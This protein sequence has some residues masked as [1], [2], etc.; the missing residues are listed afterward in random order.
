MWL[1]FISILLVSILLIIYISMYIKEEKIRDIEIEDILLSREMLIQHGEE[2]GR[3][4]KIGKK[5]DVKNF[6][7]LNLDKNFKQIEKI[8]LDLNR[9]ANRDLPKASEW[10]LDNFYIIELQYKEIRE[11]LEKE[12]ELNLNT[13]ESGLLKGYPRVYI[14]A[15]EL[16]SHTEGVL[17]EETLVDFIKAYQKESILSIKE[18]SI[19]PLMLTLALMEYIKNICVEIKA[20]NQQW[21]KAD[22]IDLSQVEDIERY[23]EEIDD[24]DS[25]YLARL[26][27]RMKKSDIETSIFSLE[28]RLNYLGTSIESTI[29]KEHINQ[30]NMKV[31]MGNCIISL[32]NISDFKW[33]SIFDKLCIVEMILKKDPL[34][35][36]ENMDLESKNYYRYHVQKLA[37]N[38]NVKEIFIAKKALELAKYEYDKGDKGKK[39]HIGYYIID[40]GREE[41]F[42]S[43]SRTDGMKGLYLNTEKYYTFPIT[44]LTL[45]IAFLLARY[46]Y[47]RSNVVIGLLV[48]FVT[49]IPI[50]NIIIAIF[51]TIFSKRFIPTHLPKLELKDEIPDVFKTFVVIPT[52]LTDEKR[53]KELVEQLEI[54]YLSNREK[55][56][57]FGL[58]GDFKDGKFEKEENDEKIIKKALKCINRL[59]E[60][61]SEDEN[62]FYYFHRDRVYS[63]S[64]EKWM[65]WEKKRGA[66]VEFN[67]LILGSKDTTYS[68]VSSNISSL[69]NK[70]KYI[71]TLDADTKMPLESAR[72][73]IGTIG[74]PLNAAVVDRE[75]N[76]VIEGYGIIQPRIDVD[77]ESSNKSIFTRIYAGQG[78]IDPYTTAVSDIYQD[79]FGEGI[80]TG[81][82]I[83]DLEVFQICLKDAIPENTVLSHDLLES[84]YIRAGLATDIQL[85]DGYPEKY[86]S[87]I[88]RLHRWTRGDWQLIRWLKNHKKNPISS[89]SKWKIRDN[90]RRSLIPVSILFTIV[91]GLTIF[92]GN[93]YLWLGISL[94][95]IFTPFILT[96]VENILYRNK[97]INKIKLNGNLITG[98]KG[99]FYQGILSFIFLPYEA[100]M[101][102][103]AILRT[104]YRVIFSNKNLLQWT[105]AFDMEKKLKND[106]RSFFLRMRSS[107]LIGI[108][109]IVLTYLINIEKIYISIFIS[110]LWIIS[111]IIAY[112]ISKE[113]IE[114]KV[115]VD[116]TYLREIARKTWDYYETFTNKENNFLPPD[117]YQEY[118]YNGVAYRTSPTN[119]GFLWVS[120][121][122][123]RD[124]GYI[125]TSKMVN[126]LDKAIS[127]VEKMEKWEG[128]LY[129][130]YSTTNLEP[131]RPYFVST[132]DSGNFISYLYVLREG[133]KE[134]L[135]KPIMDKEYLQGLKDTIGLV[136]DEDISKEVLHRLEK[137]ENEEIDQLKELKN[138]LHGIDYKKD[139]WIYNSFKM[140]EALIKEYEHYILDKNSRYSLL[141]LKQYYE[142]TLDNRKDKKIEALYENVKNIIF[143]IEN[144][145]DRIENLIDKADFR[146]LYNYDKDLFS[147]GYIVDEKELLDSYYDLLAS[148]ARTTSYIAICRGEVP[149]KHW[150]KLGRSLISKNGYRSLA[151]WTGTMFEYLMPTLIMKNYRNTLLDETYNTAINIQKDYCTNKNIP[152]GISESGFFAFDV[153]LNYQYRAFGVPILGFKRGLEEDLVVSPYS[154]ILALNF[155]PR[156]VITNINNLFREK[157][158]G[159]YG[160]YEAIDFTTRRLPANMNSGIVK[161]YMTHH[162]GMILLSINNYLNGR[163]LIERFH[164]NV[165]MKTGEILLQEKIPMELI[166]AKEREN[167]IDL[168][169]EE[170]RND[171]ILARTYDKNSLQ[172]IECHIL[173][174][175]DYSMLITNMGLGYSKKNDI[176]INRWRKDRIANQYGSF[177]YINNL[178]ENKYWSTTYEPTKVEPDEYKVQFSNDKVSFYRKD[179]DIDTKM[180]IVLLS[181][182]DGEIRKVTLTNNGDEDVLIEVCSYFELVG[183]FLE[184][185]ISH[186]VFNNLFIR[187]KEVKE[188]EGLITNRRKRGEEQDSVYIVHSIKSEDKDEISFEY[189][190]NRLKFIGRGNKLSNPQG[191]FKGLSNTVGAVLDPIMSLK[192]RIKINSG[193]SKEVYFIT[194]IGNTEEEAFNILE[195]YNDEISFSKA[196]E[197]AYTRSQT[198]I[199]YLNYKEEDI[200]LYDRL[201]SDIIFLDYRVDDRYKDIIKESIKGQEGLWAYG[202]SGDIPILLVTIKSVENLENLKEILKAYGYWSFKGLAVDLII[203]CEDESSYY[204]PLYE[205]IQEAVFECSGNV[206]GASGSIYIRKANN[207]PYEDRALLFK[208]AS[209]VIDAEEGFI[210]KEES[211]DYIPNKIFNEVK[212]DYPAVQKDLDLEYFN[213]YGG[214]S[215]DGNEYIIKLENRLNTPLP[216]IN[217]IANRNFGFT[218][219]EIG[220]G[221]S[222]SHNSRENKLTPWYNDSLINSPGEIIYLRDD[223]TGNI[224]NITPSPIREEEEYI[225]THGQGYSNF[226][227]YSQGI[228][229]DLTMYVAL[230]HNI[231]MNLIKLK[232]KS[233]FERKITLVYFMRP[234]LG[235][236]DE[237]TDKFIETYM[238]EKEG[239]FL[240]KNSTNVD[241]KNSTMFIGCSEKVRSYTGNRREFIGSLG[242]LEEPEALEKERLSN[243]VGIG[244]D[245]CCAIEMEISIPS[246]SEKELVIVLAES[247]DIENGYS[248][249][250]KYSQLNG[251]KEELDNVKKYWE[252][253]LKKIQINTPEPSMNLMM[254]SWLMYQTIVSRLWARTGFYQV[255]GAFGGR[256]QIQDA[257][258]SLY[259]ASEECK[260]QILNNCSHQFVE[261]DIQHWWHPNPKKNVH[262]GIRSKY[263]DDLLWL[264]LAV[265]KYLMVTEDYSILEVEVPYIE[266]VVLSD[267]E[268]ERYEVPNISEKTGTVYEHCIKAIEKSLKFGE[269]GIPLMGS[270]DWNDGMNKV[271]YKGKGES[272]WLGWFLGT[273][274]KNFLPICKKIGDFNR[275]E[276]YEK[277]IENIKEAIEK[278]GWDGD[279]YLRAYFD[280]GR[281]LGS[282]ENEECRIDS[283]AQSWGVLSGLGNKERTKK[284]MEAVD[285][286]LINEEEGMILLLSPPF[287]KGDL[288]PGY[289]KSYVPGV[290]E[291]GGQYTHAAAWV[292][293][294][295]ALMGDG[296]KALNLFN[297][298]NPINHTRTLIECEKYKTEPYVMAADIYGIDPHMGRGGW[299]WYTGS[300]GWIYKVG[301]EYILGFRVEGEKLYI[302][303]CIP[304]EWSRYS[305]EYKYLQTTYSI[306]VRN[307]CKLNN[308]VKYIKLDGKLVNEE[309]IKLINDNK[310]HYVEVVLNN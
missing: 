53:V 251:A 186:P 110:T 127:S 23:I 191:L 291:N 2:L 9:V 98:V 181:E 279:W 157:M 163:I 148:E 308:G 176:F 299:T 306:E 47:I 269:R 15:I 255:G 59:N 214:F 38:L 51:N 195:K 3:T 273:V 138:Y 256:D 146:P 8:Y 17:N 165:E 50:S 114:E 103:D 289:I 222:W 229:Q 67:E 254:N 100:Y 196:F 125:T 71:I 257:M 21:K 266:S 187:T 57:Y 156:E 99:S 297:I 260:K 111:P 184:S 78:G 264:P 302:N 295:F 271:G 41:I 238:D 221:F 43:L 49:F 20:T 133:L 149:K 180:D 16:I 74:H 304:K 218:V 275:A 108:G 142:K 309:Y 237:V 101:M 209:L 224:W 170:E 199:G 75:R 212:K 24:I 126:L 77:I 60:K 131:L 119:I 128:H 14:L 55:N 136:E 286:Y 278:N 188:Y 152:W 215:K 258:N 249:V 168:E 39:S 183:D 177:I 267:E 76:I 105:T 283:I 300:S 250:N 132:V 80:F 5:I 13:L 144:L 95:A 310:N 263:S 193:E 166:V 94:L 122:S 10:L 129:N 46:A 91:L 35:V 61:Y 208:W 22:E 173:S 72:K 36:Y 45:S 247:D 282:K 162:Q 34:K 33:V 226:N 223:D 106:S 86:N 225:I 234:V 219:S 228:E 220:A 28:K 201:V 217:I 123:A 252:E 233:A 294:A 52:L 118:P 158:V 284:A 303:P 206:V 90:M 44:L 141:D 27:L 48:G 140:I 64:E 248:I 150:F 7:L 265:A 124:L 207:M 261:G 116:S 147:I 31:K 211:K 40:S 232:N 104:I 244:Y 153:N 115:E 205:S 139:K 143:N 185:D 113:D 137:I 85:I 189:E 231:K 290:R 70:I 93:I 29:E 107:V 301:L 19:L 270:G 63:Q 245:P 174:S 92:P 179:G 200:R 6:L 25:S 87:Y 159:K 30:A 82:G 81:K 280:D 109:A 202:I 288:D 12:K 182:E 235:V 246:G 194:G 68:V 167:L 66:L 56:I 210:K 18:I 62:I 198:E 65:G 69:Q 277:I 241:F 120:I 84:C 130:W 293:G 307:P 281:V 274:L 58:I 292:I 26:V 169:Y 155:K 151:S 42:S 285:R 276:R 88:M 175:G 11:N 197:L 102:M 172:D 4:F 268:Q 305:I 227:H 37:K 272:I 298:I 121:L 112:I 1:I 287:D 203:L 160:F 213:G 134:Y 83:Y 97:S 296:E 96:L 161:S 216:W 204:E 89:L 192:K 243:T 259:I 242:S 236:T 135:R 117:N 230:N 164:R 154:S 171:L 79:L 239:I 178:T 190:T 32:K 145:I 240:A 54:H 253:K 262:K 73:L